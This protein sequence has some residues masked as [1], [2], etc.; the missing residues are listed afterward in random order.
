MSQINNLYDK[1]SFRKKRKSWKLIIG[2]FTA[3]MCIVFIIIVVKKMTY[4]DISIQER[5]YSVNTY[6]VKKSTLVDY[7]KING[8]VIA[9]NMINIFPDVQY[10]HL[11]SYSIRI[12]DRV[13]KNQI[14]GYI[15]P[16]QPGIVF[17][18][19]PIRTPLSGII[20][21]LPLDIGSRIT[22]SSVVAQVGDL[23]ALKIEGFVPE[24]LL[25][26]LKNNAKVAITMPAYPEITAQGRVTEVSPAIDVYSRT[27]LIRVSIDEIP[28]QMKSGMFVQLFI[29]SAEYKDILA[30]PQQAIVT[31]GGEN[32][33]FVVS[34]TKQ[35][36][37][38][39]GIRSPNALEE[40]E[41]LN[42]FEGTEFNHF[43]TEN[44]DNSGWSTLIPVELGFAIDGKVI[45]TSGVK[46]GDKIVIVGQSEL[47]NALP[48][49]IINNFQST[50]K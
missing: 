5:I 13:E 38:S 17:A 36:A 45:V 35:E 23:N 16:S 24:R 4:K 21:A 37:L 33:L 9:T 30:V 50:S 43:S 31:R 42:T 3:M 11:M 22:N 19:N 15:D 7:F 18:P 20:T 28:P 46:D 29:E 41:E 32:Y 49:R 25:E 40:S 6:E 10:G 8:D 14:I 12:G 34:Q 48:I 44:N 26:K 2:I 39:R 1:K 27:V 47:S